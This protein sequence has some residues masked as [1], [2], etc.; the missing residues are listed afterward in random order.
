VCMTRSTITACS[1]VGAQCKRMRTAVSAFALVFLAGACSSE[2]PGRFTA[3]S[4]SNQGT[5]AVYLIDT[6]SGETWIFSRG[7]GPDSWDK[8][9]T[10]PTGD[11]K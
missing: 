7:S 9:S 10:G 4:T 5:G 6:H 11:S 8:V 3:V 2:A 1:F